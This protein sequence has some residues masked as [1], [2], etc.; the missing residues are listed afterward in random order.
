MLPS[1]ECDRVGSVSAPLDRHSFYSA[2][3]IAIAQAAHPAHAAHPSHAADAAL[4]AHAALAGHA[5]RAALAAHATHAA[6]A[7]HAAHPAHAAYP[8]HAA[9]ANYF[10]SIKSLLPSNLSGIVNDSELKF[11]K[12][13][14]KTS[15]AT[16]GL[17]ARSP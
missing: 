4:A 11:D 1:G 2:D 3:F 10:I 13:N 8:A 17:G 5:A 12:H 16:R 15:G 6:L 9:D 14:Y 7:A